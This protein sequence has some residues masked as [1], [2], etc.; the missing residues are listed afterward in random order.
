MPAVNVDALCLHTYSAQPTVCVWA[1]YICITFCRFNS[2]RGAVMAVPALG[3]QQQFGTVQFGSCHG[4][5]ARAS[6]NVCYWKVGGPQSASWRLRQSIVQS[7]YHM[8]LTE[9][10]PTTRASFEHTRCVQVWQ[11]MHQTIPAAALGFDLQY[12]GDDHTHTQP[13]C[14]LEPCLF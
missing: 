7:P 1:T 3:R 14:S 12:C 5:P 10:P 2:V 6:R 11:C 8:G 4:E 9:G 13:P